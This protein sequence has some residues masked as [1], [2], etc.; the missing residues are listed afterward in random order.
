LVIMVVGLLVTSVRANPVQWPENGHYYEL[1]IVTSRH[2]WD[3]ARDE[4]ENRTYLGSPGYLATIHSAEENAFIL[5]LVS[6]TGGITGVWLGGFQ[7]EGSVEP[8]GGW[9]WVTSEPWNY[10]NWDPPNPNNAVGG[11]EDYLQMLTGPPYH[12]G[13][14]SDISNNNADLR[15]YIVEYE[16]IPDQSTR[17]SANNILFAS[18]R[19]GDQEIYIM[20]VDGSNV[21]QL[22]YNSAL[23]RSPSWSPDQSKIAFSSK[24]DGDF[25]IYT[26]DADG[27]NVVQLTHESGRDW[28]PSWSPDGS[29]IAFES[30]R[31]GDR[32]IYV[33]SADGHDSVRLTINPG[34]DTAP[35][36]SPDGTRIAFES[37]RNGD[38]EIYVMDADGAN[39]TQLTSLGGMYSSWSPDGTRIAFNSNRDGD[40]EIFVVGID[41]SNLTQLTHNS[42]LDRSPFWSPDGSQI[43]FSSDRD[44]DQEIFVMDIDGPNVAQLTN[45]SA[46]DWL[47]VWSGS[48]SLIIEDLLIDTYDVQ[49]DR[50]IKIRNGYENGLVFYRVDGENF[51]VIPVEMNSNSAKIPPFPPG[52]LVEYYIEVSDSDGNILTDPPD[53]PLSL[54]A[55][56]ITSPPE[57]VVSRGF[58][59]TPTDNVL[60]SEAPHFLS[61]ELFSYRRQATTATLFYQAS[62]ADDL[63]SIDVA[64]DSGM[65]SSGIPPFPRGTVI[66]YYF[67]AS[68]ELGDLLAPV[69]APVERFSYVVT[70]PEIKVSPGAVFFGIVEAAQTKIDTLTV[71]NAGNVPLEIS[72]I[73]SGNSRIR[74]L[75]T[76][77][78]VEPGASEAL[79]LA[80]TPLTDVIIETELVLESNDPTK[81]S[82]A[83]PL[84]AMLP[85]PKPEPISNSGLL[86]IGPTTPTIDDEVVLSISGDFPA[87]NASIATHIYSI[88]DLTITFDITTEWVGDAFDGE[89]SVVTSWIVDEKIGRLSAGTYQLVIR[90]NEIE[91]LSSSLNVRE[92]GASRGLISL[93]FDMADGDQEQRITG[94][95]EPGRTYEMQINL[96]R[97]LQIAGWSLTIEF[98]P[99]QVRYSSN[100]FTPSD[101]I[102]GLIP[103]VDEQTRSISVG[104]TVLGSTAIGSGQGALG[105]LSFEVLE[106]FSGSTDL[107]A[108]ENNFRF[109]GGGSEKYQVLSVVT[110][111]EEHVEPPTQGDFDGSSKVD[112]T[113]FFLFADAFGGTDPT[114]DLDRDG[115]VGFDDFFIFADNFGKEARAKLMA[116]AREYLGLPTTPRLEQNFPNPFNASTTIRYHVAQTGPV[117]LDIFDLSGQS[118][119]TLVSDFQSPGSYEV[120]WNGADG[121][122]A[123]A[124]TGIYLLR[125]RSGGFVD[126]GKVLLVK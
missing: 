36:W 7:P 73:R 2:T 112:F 77:M 26:M 111:T 51:S 21:A 16:P 55:Y 52:S 8:N 40:H 103:L 92:S 37:N 69:N 49:N 62:G 109:E 71:S 11:T 12:V 63:E 31:D 4:A 106:G 44:G 43:V 58:I 6:S 35:A 61:A 13:K 30:E 124:S 15:P 116:L 25:E 114:F 115:D 42:A 90:V 27:S 104:G 20:D 100:S 87:S 101:Y 10:T 17:T 9:R 107:V 83:V 47:P 93:D 96:K 46:L 59:H 78:S 113:D 60:F 89:D 74:P 32:E 22:T 53:A 66:E 82:I 120:S 54:H 45:N 5:N 84:S 34:I 102:P 98:D 85:S 48:G 94:D 41:G 86:I 79:L 119:R 72:S 105:T 118:I 110:I 24:R 56:S 121:Q 91:F 76:A 108:T 19:D 97:G 39:V 75:K 1:V 64:F 123:R 14:W 29:K 126:V 18:D 88:T 3:Q 28:F 65:V 117:H 122:R 33:M 125:L 81:E 38:Q 95:A 50:E 70:G 67:L 99:S 57:G 23:D 68:D 80:F